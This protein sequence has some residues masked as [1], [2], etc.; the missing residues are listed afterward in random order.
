[1]LL[2]FGDTAGASPSVSMESPVP[3]AFITQMTPGPSEVAR[4][5][6]AM[7]PSNGETPGVDGVVG[8]TRDDWG[9]W[10]GPG[11]G[12]WATGKLHAL[13]SNATNPRTPPMWACIKLLRPLLALV[14]VVIGFV[15]SGHRPEISASRREL[16]AR[17]MHAAGSPYWPS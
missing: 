12:F 3:S 17:W 15:T 1:M 5:T 16:R 11:D 13:A 7:W 2:P 8:V 10:L 6:Y 4:R 9:L 14:A